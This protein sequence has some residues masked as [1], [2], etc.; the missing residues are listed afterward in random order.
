MPPAP[1]PFPAVHAEE[2]ADDLL[3]IALPPPLPLLPSYRAG[4]SRSAPHAPPLPFCKPPPHPSFPSSAAL[5]PLSLLLSPHLFSHHHLPRSTSSAT[6][7]PHPSPPTPSLPF[8]SSLQLLPSKTS[9]PPSLPTHLEELQ[10][11]EDKVYSTSDRTSHMPPHPSSSSSSSP[12]LRHACAAPVRCRSA[13]SLDALSSHVNPF[14]T[15]A[16]SSSMAQQRSWGSEG[17]RGRTV[18]VKEGGK[19]EE[20][21]RE[22]GGDDGVQRA[23]C[24]TTSTAS[25]SSQMS[26]STPSSRWRGWEARDT[27]D[28]DGADDEV[29]GD[30]SDEEVEDGEEPAEEAAASSTLVRGARALHLQTSGSFSSTSAP[31][32]SCFSPTSPFFDSSLDGGRHSADP[33][34]SAGIGVFA[35][36]LA[37]VKRM[38]SANPPIAIRSRSTGDRA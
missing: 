29:D 8:S 20:K 30:L 36:Q 25:T 7:K 32:A 19:W 38:R 34:L 27:P 2:G 1:A 16:A 14:V 26:S 10:Q 35:A 15:R 21:E 23:L 22:E 28:D 33:S 9:P 11:P 6:H 3:T 13:L 4:D 37:T 17:S 18:A 24:Y 31:S 12:S 5:P